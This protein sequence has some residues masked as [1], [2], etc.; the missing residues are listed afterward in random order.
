VKIFRTSIHARLLAHVWLWMVFRSVTVP[1][2]NVFGASWIQIRN[3]LYG[4]GSAFLHQQEK[5]VKTL[6]SAA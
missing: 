2:P 1:D 3:Y 4:S 6:I 5:N